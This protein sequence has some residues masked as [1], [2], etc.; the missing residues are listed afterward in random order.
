MSLS[1][2]QGVAVVTGGSGG[3]GSAVVRMLASAGVPVAL[4][5]HRGREAADAIVREAGSAASIAAYPWS[6][7]G[8]AEAVELIEAVTRAQGPVRY[9]VSCS[10]IAQESAF[11]QLR[12]EEWQRILATNLTANLA[13]VRAGVTAMMKAGFGRIVLVSSVA[14]VRGIAGQSVYAASKA[15]LDGFVRSLAHECATFGVTVNSVAPGYI[16]TA[17]L[18]RVP[19]RTRKTLS[20]AIPARRLGRPEEV[21]QLV[22]YLLAEQ[23][24][25]VTGQ[26]WAIDG[27]LSS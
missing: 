5:Y 17:M 23:A 27:G 25:Y 15:G 10:G 26:T 1:Y 19:E 21:A 22:A 14:G 8:A 6:S 4:T 16:E 24:G 13:L 3:I 9:I 20:A 18:D 2:A 11:F 12:E 7:A